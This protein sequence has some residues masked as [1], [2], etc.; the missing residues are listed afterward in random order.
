MQIE[1]AVGQLEARLDE[2]KT[3]RDITAVLCHPHPQY[4]GSM[5]DGVVDT[6]AT[7]MLDHGINCV[8]FNFRGVGASDGR[9]DDGVG[10]VADLVA[11]SGWVT[12]TY[13]NHTLWLGGYSFGSSI[14]FKALPTLQPTFALLIAPPVGVMAFPDDISVDGVYA[15]AGDRDDFVN[16][17]QLS[18]RFGDQAQVLSGADH[19]FGGQHPQLQDAVAQA[20]S[21]GLST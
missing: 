9:Y 18:A 11:V 13:P 21:R 2:A 17:E 5:H 3:S 4:G 12:S 7:V 16:T 15:I 6:V 8:R 19:F 14:V 20:V 1:G 10:E